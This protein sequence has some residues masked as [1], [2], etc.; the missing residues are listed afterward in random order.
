MAYDKYMA[1]KIRR[2]NVLDK[3][4]LN[5]R[6][7]LWSIIDTTGMSEMSHHGSLVTG[8]SHLDTDRYTASTASAQPSFE[9]STINQYVSQQLH[10]VCFVFNPT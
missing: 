3:T 7:L 4:I 9:Q 5:R 10:C 1:G 8:R 6:A 2:F